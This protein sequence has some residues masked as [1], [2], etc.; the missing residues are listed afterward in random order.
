[1]QEGVLRDEKA[2]EGASQPCLQSVM[3]AS[4]RGLRGTREQRERGRAARK[5]NDRERERERELWRLKER[6]KKRNKF[7]KFD[8]NF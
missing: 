3:V 8:L 4:E 1:M 5:R 6:E 7:L 2:T